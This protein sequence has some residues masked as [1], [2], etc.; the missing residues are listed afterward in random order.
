MVLHLNGVSTRFACV[1]AVVLSSCHG[2]SFTEFIVGPRIGR[3]IAVTPKSSQI[4][5]AQQLVNSNGYPFEEHEVSSEDGYILSLHRIPKGKFENTTNKPRRP[6]AL[7]Q[8][9][10]LASSDAFLF[11]GP[12]YDLPYLLADAGYDVWLSNMRGNIYSNKHQI[13]DSEKDPEYW[14][15]SLHEVGQYDLPAIIDY[16]LNITKEH[17]LYFLGHSVGST[18]A[19]IM[20]S[21]RPQYNAKIKLHLALAPLV[22]VLHEIS[23]P[24]KVFLGSSVS[25]T[26]SVVARNILNVFPRRDYF[27]KLLGALCGNG[28]PTQFLC[29]IFIYSLVGIDGEQFN[30][31]YIPEF[32]SYFPA[33]SSVYLTSHAMQMYAEGDFRPLDYQNPFMNLQK[34]QGLSLP[35]Y[36]LSLV[37]HP[38]S[39]HYGDGDT[40]V[41]EEDISFTESRLPRVVGKVRVP[42]THFNHMDFMVGSDAKDLV[43]KELIYLMNKHR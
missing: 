30:S 4:S 39:L 12:E 25:L 22:Y 21:M 9:G 43:Y 24:H 5:L 35:S 42:F 34:Y 20:G 27:S 26:Q 32:L 41:T 10:L 29:L 14:K 33:G 13:F 19:F 40:L 3:G 38:V 6:I 36:N 28:V 2:F 23:F 7:F 15:F 8:H 17:S 31:S 11:R 37:D 16:I 18:A 1:L